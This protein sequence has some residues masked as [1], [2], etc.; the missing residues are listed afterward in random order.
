M[1]TVAMVKRNATCASLREN[2]EP[3]KPM[4]G[5]IRA[6]DHAVDEAHAEQSAFQLAHL[7]TSGFYVESRSPSSLPSSACAALLRVQ[8]V[9]KRL[10]TPMPSW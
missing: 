3:K 5:Q 1:M 9:E 4:S 7:H 6:G 10:N 2:P 8:G